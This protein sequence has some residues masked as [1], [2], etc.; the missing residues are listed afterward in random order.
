M[1]LILD[2]S[3]TLALFL[4]F[5]PAAYAED[6]TEG[7]PN[8]VAVKMDHLGNPGVWIPE[9]KAK[10]LFA[11][12]EETISL[13]LQIAEMDALLATREARILNLKGMIADS[14]AITEKAKLIMGDAL[15]MQRDAEI[16]V[17]KWYRHPVLWL[18]VGVVVTV[19]IQV[20]GAKVM[21]AVLD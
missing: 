11:D 15:T 3:L 7:P 6:P 21:D 1:R 9:A 12:A 4:T 18:T 17:N 5:T 20:G 13:R 2:V 16:R 10:A 8:P 19:L 14:Q